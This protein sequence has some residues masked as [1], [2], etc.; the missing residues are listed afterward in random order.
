MRNL[1]LSLLVVAAPLTAQVLETRDT[2]ELERGLKRLIDVFAIVEAQAA[3]RAAPDQVIYGGAIPGM[4]RQLDPHSV[5]FNREQFEQLQEME[6]SMSK[7]FGSIVSVLP[8]RVI[9]LQVQAGSPA[10]KAGLAPGDE[11]VIINNIPLARLDLEQLIQVLSMTRQKPAQIGVRRQG[12]AGMLSMTMTPAELLAPSVDRVFLLSGGTGYVRATSFD[13]DTG[14]RIQEAIEKLGGNRL[15]RLVL[16]L[17][18]NPGGVMQAALETAALFLDPGTRIMSARGRGKAEQVVDVPAE[19]KPYRFKLAVLINAK[20]ASAS[21]IVAGALQD[22]DRAL[23]LGEPSFGKG[24]VQSVY[25]LSDGAGM[26]LTTAFYYTPSGRSIQKPLKDVELGKATAV[27]ERPM[28]KTANGRIVRGGGGIEPDEIVYP[29]APSRLRAVLEMSGAFPTFAT[30]W[31]K[32]HRAE[33]K[34]GME[35]QPG[36]LDEFQVWLSQRNIRPGL[37]EW[38]RERSGL[39]ARLTQEILNQAISVNAGDEVEVRNDRVVTRAL[40]LIDPK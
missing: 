32:T 19:A 21:E 13:A 23:V 18:E 20:S 6:R 1:W 39:V 16:D 17:R 34:S 28:Y 14:K 15:T 7:G 30:E 26:A 3:D 12:T 27:A 36:T 38:T 10:S 8:G 40:A 33:V 31:L 35:L 37:G 4:L 22:H 2:E 11:I 5:F 25:P 24:L 29:E 9:V